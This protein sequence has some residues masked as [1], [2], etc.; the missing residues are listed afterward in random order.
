MT[1]NKQHGFSIVELLVAMTIGLL[2]MA[3]VGTVFLKSKQTYKVQEEFSRLQENGRFALDYMARFVRGAGY[4]GCASSISEMTNTLNDSGNMAWNFATGIEGYEA[5]GSGIGDT[6]ILPADPAPAAAGDEGNWTTSGGFNVPSEL[7]GAAD[8]VLPGS[9]ILVARTADDN[10]VEIVDNNMSAQLFAE[11]TTEEPG[12]CPDGSDKISGLCDGDVLLVSDCN[13]SVAFQATNIQKAGGGT[14]LNVVHGNAGITPGN[15]ISSWGGS[16]GTYSNL[17]FGPGSE[18]MKVSTKVFYV[19]LGVNGPALFLKRADG[20]GMEI[21]E[22]V[23]SLQVLYGEDTDPDPDNIPNRFVTADNV[24][25]FEN[26]VAVK[27]S[28]LLVS[29]DEIDHWALNNDTFLMNG[30]SAATGVT[31]DPVPVDAATN[32]TGADRRMRRVMSG[33]IKLRNRGFTL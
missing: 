18:V 11:V 9:D 12:A 2:V 29:S 22:G 25:D 21:I 13:K 17:Q 27:V 8:S 16:S 24:S 1:R 6:L 3:G 14:K 33:I 19:G 7:V 26:V 28:L 5:T 15:D 10:G 31:V 32:P 23:E 30:F 4:S 20:T